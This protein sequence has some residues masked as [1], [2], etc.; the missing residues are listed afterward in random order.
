[1]DDNILVVKRKNNQIKL[2]VTKRKRN[3][4]SSP[5]YNKV[6]NPNSAKDLALLMGDLK[7]LFNAPIERAFKIL[8][9]DEDS[10]PKDFFMWKKG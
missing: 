7:L 1:M 6:L 2:K 9:E 5:Q 4:Y 3:Q 10:L 8:K